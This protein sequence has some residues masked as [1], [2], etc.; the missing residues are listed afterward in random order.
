[1]AWRCWPLTRLTC[2]AKLQTMNKLVQSSTSSKM[3]LAFF[4]SIGAR[5]FRGGVTHIGDQPPFLQPVP[6][7]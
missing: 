5:S 4:Q 3:V 7:Q 6:G 2:Q 1:M